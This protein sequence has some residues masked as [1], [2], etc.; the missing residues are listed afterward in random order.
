M[1]TQNI[2]Q[3]K[4]SSPSI[5]HEPPRAYI[6]VNCTNEESLRF[7]TSIDDANPHVKLSLK[8]GVDIK[9]MDN[10]GDLYSE[11]DDMHLAG[12]ALYFP[13]K[14]VSEC[15]DCVMRTFTEFVIGSVQIG[16]E[17]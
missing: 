4:L 3:I 15:L 17:F 8:C 16:S 1:K 7:F 9:K 5:K 10:H 12:L 14:D 6:A 2:A 11:L 13:S